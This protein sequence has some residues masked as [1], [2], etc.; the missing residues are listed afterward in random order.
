MNH[1]NQTVPHFD[2]C[3]HDVAAHVFPEKAAQT[4]KRY[5]RRNLRYTKET[6]VKEWVARVSELNSYLKDFPATNGNA[7]QPLDEDELLDIW[8]YGVPQGWRR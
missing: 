4:Q 3:L 5:M 8:E 2:L 7:S 6:S 1:G